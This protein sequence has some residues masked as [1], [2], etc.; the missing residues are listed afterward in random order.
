MGAGLSAEM[1]RPENLPTALGGGSMPPLLGGA[2]MSGI[3]P[4]IRIVDV[5][6]TGT[7]PPAEVCEIGYCDL[8]RVDGQLVVQ[9][10]RSK[11]CGVKSMPAE[12]RAVHHITLADVEGLPPFDADGFL[13]ASA[14]CV[15]FA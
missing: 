14:H 9:T 6:T 8:Q 13:E 7:E 11:L 12:V 15:A 5:E 1:A 3:T 10:P 4:T 2:A